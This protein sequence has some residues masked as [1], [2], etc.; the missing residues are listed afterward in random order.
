MKVGVIGAAGLVGSTTAF[1]LAIQNL[2][3]EIVLIDI[4]ENL[5][6]AH[7]WDMEQAVM[8]VS[9]TRITDGTWESLEGC[10]MV[11]HCASVNESNTASRDECL[12]KNC[13]IVASTAEHITKHCPDAMIITAANPV[14][15]LN[16]A[17]YHYTGICPQRLIGF[18][19]NDTLRLKWAISK[20]ERV[21]MD[22][23]QAISVGEHG[24]STVPLF[25]NILVHGEKKVY[26]KQTQER[27]RDMIVNYFTRY[28]ALKSG[29]SSGWTTAVSLVQVCKKILL[30][31]PDPV[32]CSVI[33]QGEYGL[34]H[35]SLSVPVRLGKNGVQEILEIP[36]DGE[37][38]AA[39]LSAAQKTK[40]HIQAMG[41]A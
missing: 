18:S 29:R 32:P 28:Q 20:I 2:V 21:P 11:I 16:Y 14:D 30:D 40:D 3:E 1:Y 23:V 26:D 34:D 9:D 25:S 36:M 7:S 37:E 38:H 19:R 33:L 41:F 13:A 15:V 24:F 8:D 31:D 4:K 10:D 27:I 35:L 17:F 22:A 5:R 6:L 39:F 12:E